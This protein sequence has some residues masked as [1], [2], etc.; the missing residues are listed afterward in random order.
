VP[1]TVAMTP[2]VFAHAGHWLPQLA[3]VAPLAVL[4][5]AAAVNRR[6]DRAT[7][8][9]GREAASQPESWATPG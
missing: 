8:A 1:I 6:R 2:F 7:A 5:G 9:G 4:V 3:F